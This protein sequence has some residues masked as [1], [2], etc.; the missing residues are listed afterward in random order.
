VILR[1]ESQKGP[2]V[3]I[4]GAVTPWRTSDAD[5][6][7]EQSSARADAHAPGGAAVVQYEW[8]GAWVVTAHGSFDMQSIKPLTDALDTAARKHPKVVLDAS[9][10]TF[11]DSA[12]LNLLILTHRTAA[13][14]VAAPPP[15]LR[16]L[17]EL[18]GTDTLLQVRAT[19]EDAAAS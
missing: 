15:Q 18:T 11:A 8:R 14:R 1:G 4:D 2:E 13:L 6:S 5:G 7:N 10:I 12:L 9:G 3:S 17:L 16:R 19:V